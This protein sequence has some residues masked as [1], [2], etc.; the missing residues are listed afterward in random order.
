MKIFDEGID[1]PE[2][3]IAIM[4]S[5]SGNPRQ[6]IQ[7]RGRILRHHP[8]KE[9]SLIY[10]IIV[11][12]TISIEHGEEFS[13]L[14]KKII[15][16]ELIR[17][18]EFSESAIGSLVDAYQALLKAPVSSGNSLSANPGELRVFL[19][20]KLSKALVSLSSQKQVA[21]WKSEALAGNIPD[22][23]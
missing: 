8:G 20:E 15:R 21:K 1:V 4:L 22:N 7:R 19:Q 6:Y 3:K 5:N 13:E 9:K 18:R 2:A 23:P 17:Y 10:D 16:K 12:P 11:I 14:E